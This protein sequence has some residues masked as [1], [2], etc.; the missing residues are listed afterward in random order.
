MQH[1]TVQDY[2]SFTAYAL[3]SVHRTLYDALHYQINVNYYIKYSILLWSETSVKRSWKRLS[4]AHYFLPIPSSI[5]STCSRSSFISFKS[6]V[7]RLCLPMEND[8]DSTSSV[9]HLHSKFMQLSLNAIALSKR[10]K[11]LVP[12]RRLLHLPDF[13]KMIRP[14]EMSRASS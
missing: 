2:R 8:N 5:P 4:T 11:V 6:I 1:S 14:I 7:N 12:C 10:K 9:S 3:Y 13:Q